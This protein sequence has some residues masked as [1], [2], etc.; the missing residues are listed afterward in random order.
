MGRL[1]NEPSPWAKA[2]PARDREEWPFHGDIW[3]Y[4]SV[5]DAGVEYV[6]RFTHGRVEWIQ[7]AEECEKDWP[8]HVSALLKDPY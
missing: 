3:I 5:D 1:I 7:P 2:A 6:V 8:P 4:A